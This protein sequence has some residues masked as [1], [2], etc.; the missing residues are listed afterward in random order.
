MDAA[1]RS[2]SAAGLSRLAE[3]CESLSRLLAG[4][5]ESPRLRLEAELGC[6]LAHRLVGA[7]LQ[8]APG[9]ALPL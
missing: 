7:L 8:R 2:G 3:H 9:L 1:R 4:E 5:T 6:E